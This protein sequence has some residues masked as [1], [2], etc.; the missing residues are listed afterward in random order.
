MHRAS[1][2]GVDLLARSEHR[3]RSG[4]LARR[5]VDADQLTGDAAGCEHGNAETQCTRHPEHLIWPGVANGCVD[6]RDIR[7]E[8]VDFADTGVEERRDVD[9][10][11]F[12]RDSG[13]RDV[14]IEVVGNL[15]HH[16]VALLDLLREPVASGLVDGRAGAVIAQRGIRLDQRI[17]TLTAPT[18]HG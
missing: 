11:S 13:V 5:S 9:L 8:A 2:Q 15:L 12:D 16:A 3:D 4:R 14:L 17:E 10:A 6:L 7:L 1:P 18:S